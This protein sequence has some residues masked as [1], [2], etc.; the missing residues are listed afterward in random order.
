M[1]SILKIKRGQSHMLSPTA[2]REKQA[3]NLVNS[4]QDIRDGINAVT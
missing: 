4:M 1:G 2:F 3:R